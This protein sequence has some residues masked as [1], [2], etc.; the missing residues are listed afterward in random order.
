MSRTQ[1]LDLLEKAQV[2]RIRGRGAAM[3]SV[4]NELFSPATRHTAEEVVGK[5]NGRIDPSVGDVGW[6]DLETAGCIYRS[7]VSGCR[8]PPAVS[9]RTDAPVADSNT[10]T[11]W[12]VTMSSPVSGAALRQGTC[13]Q[14]NS[15]RSVAALHTIRSILVTPAGCSDTADVRRMVGL[16]WGRGPCLRV[17]VAPAFRCWVASTRPG[18]RGVGTARPSGRGTTG[19]GEVDMRGGVAMGRVRARAM[20]AA[21]AA[22][23]S[24]PS[25]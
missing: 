15:E 17:G 3:V 18:T 11:G 12:S 16:L 9:V 22:M 8:N 2:R 7:P 24:R 5:Q 20:A 14:C 23:M 10:A 19:E 1:R 6:I 4:M 13:P 21:V 25:G